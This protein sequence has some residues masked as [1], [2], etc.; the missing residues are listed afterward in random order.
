MPFISIVNYTAC[1]GV[2]SVKSRS[3]LETSKVIHNLVSDLLGYYVRLLL[4]LHK[5][6]QNLTSDD[7]W[8][9]QRAQKHTG[10]D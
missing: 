2:L 3:I 9:E 6:N 4:A 8:I 1:D 7:Y 10:V 5:R